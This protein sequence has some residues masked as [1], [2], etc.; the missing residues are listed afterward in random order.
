MQE[1][2]KN[3]GARRFMFTRNREREMVPEGVKLDYIGRPYRASPGRG[4]PRRAP[5]RAGPDPARGADGKEL[6]VR[7]RCDAEP[8]LTRRRPTARSLPLDRAADRLGLG[9]VGLPPLEHRVERAAQ[10]GGVLGRVGVV[11]VRRAA[12]AQRARRRR[13]RTRRASSSRRRRARRP[14]SRRAGREAASPP[15]S[16]RSCIA[17]NESLG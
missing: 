16:T 12:V 13:P 7:G 11:G 8:S 5:H 6:N 17:S 10:P 9:R 14:G 15:A 3:M 2:P 1:E 4:L